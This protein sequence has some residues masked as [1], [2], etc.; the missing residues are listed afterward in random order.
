VSSLDSTATRDQD[1]KSLAD[2]YRRQ[3]ETVANNATLALFVM[4]ERQHCT[5][6]NA[7]AERL[8]GFS[9]DELRG[10]PL[11]EH[12]HHTR[13]DGTPYPLEECPIDQAFPQNMREQGEEIFVHKDG[14]FFPVSFTASP[15]IEDGSPVGTIIE[16][17]D[18][19][20]ERRAEEEST[21]LNA[22][23]RRVG[24]EQAFLAEAGEVLSSSLDYDVTLAALTRLAVQGIADWCAVDELMPD[25]TIRRIAVAH[26][27]PAMVK[28]AYDLQ[29]RYPPNPQAPHGAAHVIRTGEPELI[30][31]ISDELLQSVTVD[32]EHLRIIRQVGLRSYLAVPLVA[33]GSVLGA[34]TL[35]SGES[36]RRYGERDLRLAQ[37]LARRAAIAIDNA[38]LFRESEEARFRLEEQAVELEAQAEELQH[39]ALQLEETQTELEVMNEELVRQARAAEA[40]RVH[41]E[42]ATA[43]LDAFFSAAPVAAAFVDRDLRYRRMNAALA[44]IDGVDPEE[45]IGRRL[46][47]VAPAVAREVEPLYREVLE[48]GQPILN[49]EVS[50]PRTGGADEMGHFLCN[51][52]PVRGADGEILG[53]GLVALDVT[54]LKQVQERERVFAQV[55]E[56]SRNEI[57]LFDADTLRFQQVN[58]GAREN[59]G[60]SLDELREMT[61]LSIKPDFTEEQFEELV[62]PLREGTRDLVQFETV[63]ERRDGSRYPV[64]VRLQLSRADERP[65]FVALILDATERKRVERELTAAR[66][67]AEQANQAKSQFLTVMSHELRTPLNAIMG[68]GDLLE[69]EVAGPLNEK[70]QLHLSRMK[71]GAKTL[72]ELINQILS[73]ARIE[74]G[75]E[76]AVLADVDLRQVA[77][78]AQSLI[79]SL[80]SQKG[81]R[82][83][84][85]LPHEPV[86]VQTDAG[87]VRQILLN[88]LGNAVKFTDAGEVGLSLARSNGRVEVRVRDTGP[89]IPEDFHGRV[90][91]P[92]VQAD[93]SQT[94]QHGGTGLGLAVSR[95][96]ARLLG[97]DVTVESRPGEGSTFILTLPTG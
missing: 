45:A 48:T 86:Q 19:T 13:P 20:E 34:L 5:Y 16:V 4:D 74:S 35:V 12:I 24:E 59:L 85:D 27:D 7:A 93:F 64:D 8:T 37:E 49:R 9:L 6:M 72:L 83:S 77:D 53:V 81:L 62:L 94:R 84:L 68:Y 39:Q 29:E 50:A 76:E 17:R 40:A 67:T 66:D 43:L 15:I 52:F 57:F 33:R 97:G 51:Y 46:R 79:G 10:K 82:L 63:H 56:D 88:L 44:A 87:K 31:E 71:G 95:E 89:G 78:E 18:I 14:H 3:L 1:G 42:A 21:R 28:L 58:R 47:E 73:L 22:E 41:A 60:Y 54:E 38:R 80:A 75:R 2:H 55:L 65:V 69:A 91:E 30:P 11:H 25:G 32:E 90:F 70:Q 26:P 92:F 61:P 96:L 36:G 23:A